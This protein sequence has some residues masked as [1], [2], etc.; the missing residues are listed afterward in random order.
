M[1]PLFTL[2]QDSE[3]GDMPRDTKLYVGE[4]SDSV[5]KSDL[6]TEF[7]RFGKLREVWVAH[8]PPGFAF[9]D[10]VNR[11]DT[12]RAMRQMNGKHYCGSKL[13][14]EFA[15]SSG[16][17]SGG[18]GQKSGGGSSGGRDKRRR[19]S[20]LNS[21][22]S[23]RRSPSPRPRS[24]PPRRNRTPPPRRSLSPPR[25]SLPLPPLPP[26]PPPVEYDSRY[27]TASS[28][29]PVERDPRY[30]DDSRN[31]WDRGR[32]PPPP[33]PPLPASVQPRY[34]SRS[35]VSGSRRRYSLN[36]CCVTARLLSSLVMC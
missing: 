6:E 14:V 10:F 11:S 32:S 20:P 29:R 34:R 21:S 26:P 36:Q 8:N 24:P 7:G 2:F 23:R 16:R 27:R 30:R 19:L 12:L 17:R 28:S 33:P 5:K 35:P 15:K 25:R 13:R 4:L 22:S 9:I 1:F 18:R 31:G 3:D